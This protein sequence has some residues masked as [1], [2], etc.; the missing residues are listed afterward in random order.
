[1]IERYIARVLHRALG[2]CITLIDL[3]ARASDDEDAGEDAGDAIHCIEGAR[4]VL[5]FIGWRR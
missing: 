1:M 2:A 5:H 3:G 4:D